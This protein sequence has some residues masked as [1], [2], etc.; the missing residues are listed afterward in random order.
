MLIM[1]L[2]NLRLWILSIAM[3]ALVVGF[4]SCEQETYMQGKRLYAAHCQN[5]HAS[6]GIGLSKLIPPLANSDYLSDNQSKIAC[7]I[8]NGQSGR[9]LVN[10]IVY[11]Q[12]MP[13]KKFTEVQITNIINYINHA[14]SN[15]YGVTSL[16][17][18]TEELRN[19]AQ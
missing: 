7:I 10:G 8:R 4:S 12:E 3:V 2:L 16:Q 1:S 9:I 11:Q 19:C 6:D 14:W 17:K 18:V 15:D 5:C 13:G